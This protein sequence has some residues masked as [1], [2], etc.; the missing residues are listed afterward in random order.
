[1]VIGISGRS[2][3][4]LD[5]VRGGDGAGRTRVSVVMLMAAMPPL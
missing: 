3:D 1:M 5:E 2:R 4:R